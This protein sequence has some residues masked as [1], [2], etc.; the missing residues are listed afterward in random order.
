MK[1]LVDSRKF[2]ECIANAEDRGRFDEYMSGARNYSTM[3]LMS[4]TLPQAKTL[5]QLG[6]IWLDFTTIARLMHT[7]PSMIYRLCIRA[8]QLE[9]CWMH[10]DEGGEWHFTTLSG[11]TK[12]QMSAAIPRIREYL[13]HVVNGAYGEWVPVVWAEK[14]NIGKETEEQ[15]EP[16]QKNL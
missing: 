5:T 6:A 11:L 4:V 10:Q 1:L 2:R 8:D 3:P 9:D 13:Q 15:R 14:D 16:Q 7:D 12:E